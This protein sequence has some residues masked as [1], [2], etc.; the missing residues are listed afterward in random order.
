MHCVRTTP[1]SDG[2]TRFAARWGVR[3]R[4][5][6]DKGTRGQG[7]K[8]TRGQGDKGTRGQGDKGTRGQGDKGTRGQG[9][10]GTRGQGDRDRG[11]RIRGQGSRERGENGSF[12]F[13]P[14]PLVTFSD[15]ACTFAGSR[16]LRRRCCRRSVSCRASWPAVS[17]PR[18]VSLA[19]S[20]GGGAVGRRRHLHDGPPLR[21]VLGVGGLRRAPSS[22]TMSISI[23]AT[24]SSSLL[25]FV[26]AEAIGVGF[27]RTSGEPPSIATR[28]I[29]GPTLSVSSASARIAFDRHVVH[30]SAVG[31]VEIA[32]KVFG[33]RVISAQW[34]L[35]ITA[36][37]GRNWHCGS[38]PITKVD[39]VMGITVPNAFPSDWT[40]RLSFIAQNLTPVMHTRRP[41][42][43]STF[44]RCS[45]G[46]WPTVPACERRHRHP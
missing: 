13:P 40:T 14:C 22:S 1:A 24:E 15:G 39:R 27:H 43:A 11:T 6:G 46:G 36:L 41:S 32:D 20:C 2:G 8:G 26:R 7:D 30:I 21:H 42:P 19:P 25:S 34:R 5:Q 38:R 28:N 18:R 16:G 29:S 45:P 44:P 4:G 12:L 10:K 35:L 31:A 3:T 9:D 17:P 37:A 23:A 33:T